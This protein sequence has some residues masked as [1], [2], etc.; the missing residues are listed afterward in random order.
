MRRTISIVTTFVLA[1]A[2]ACDGA[3]DSKKGTAAASVAPKGEPKPVAAKA[4]PAKADPAKAEPA[5]A[6]PAAPSDAK[7]EVAKTPPAAPANV[8]DGARQVAAWLENPSKAPAPTF[9]GATTEVEL[10]EFCGACDGK[11]KKTPKTNKLAGTDAIAKRARELAEASP[12]EVLSAED[13]IT[14]KKDCCTFVPDPKLGV[15]D[16]VVNLEA[17]CMTLDAAGKPTALT[18]VDVSGS[19]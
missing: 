5:K 7:A 2:L 17:V 9:V 8:E 16:N 14:C 12:A 13:K 18:R 19:W 4:D 6:E 10:R 11:D 3:T 15:G 1:G